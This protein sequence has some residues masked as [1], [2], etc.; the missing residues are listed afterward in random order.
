MFALCEFDSFDQNPERQLDHVQV[1]KQ[2]TDKASGV[3]ADAKL[4]QAAEKRCPTLMLE[5]LC[6]MRLTA[7]VHGSVKVG[8]VDQFS[9]GVNKPG[10]SNASLFANNVSMVTP[11]VALIVSRNRR[12]M[13]ARPV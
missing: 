5:N 9:V 7:N 4:I 1:D 12:R 10:P 13:R 8:A 3:D 11:L 6:P 2:F